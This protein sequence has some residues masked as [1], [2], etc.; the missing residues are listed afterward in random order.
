MSNFLSGELRTL[1]SRL[2]DHDHQGVVMSGDEVWRLA[3]LLRNYADASLLLEREVARYRRADEERQTR[4]RINA[5]LSTP[6]GNVLK[7]PG[8]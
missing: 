1:A 2:G 3:R 8:H 7:F 6:G 5:A 4:D